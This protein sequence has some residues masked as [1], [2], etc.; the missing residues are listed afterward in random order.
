MWG[1]S[2]AIA[3]LRRSRALQRLHMAYFPAALVNAAAIAL[4]P[5]FGALAHVACEEVATD[6]SILGVGGSKR[7]HR[8]ARAR[9]R[10]LPRHAHIARAG[11]RLRSGR[12]GIGKIGIG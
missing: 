7:G 10:I 11:Q 9:P 1:E 6:E 8:A 5:G 12:L 2:T 4:Q 3:T